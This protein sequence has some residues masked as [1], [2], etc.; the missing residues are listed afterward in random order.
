MNDFEY[1]DEIRRLRQLDEFVEAMT[2]RIGGWRGLAELCVGCGQAVSKC[3]DGAA[4]AADFYSNAAL[5]MRMADEE[6]A[7]DTDPVN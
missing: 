3:P 1:L 4:A 7:E 2:T 5:A 6:E